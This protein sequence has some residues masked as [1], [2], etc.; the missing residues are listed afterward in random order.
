MKITADRKALSDVLA[1]VSSVVNARHT[2]PLLQ[3]VMLDV[4]DGALTLRATDL[5]VSLQYTMANAAAEKNGR[6][7][8]PATKLA[9]LVRD[10]RADT[11]SLAKKGDTV[12]VTCGRDKLEMHSSDPDHF[13]AFPAFSGK[14]AMEVDARAFGRSLARTGKSIATER[15]RY[16]LN[17]VKMTP[18]ANLIE[19]C[20]TD[21]RRLALTKMPGKG[22]EISYPVIIPRR[23]IDLMIRLLAEVGEDTPLSLEINEN[24]MLAKYG[25][26]IA[27]TALVDGQFPEYW[28]VIPTTNDKTV[29]VSRTELIE[30]VKLATHMT[31]VESST[32]AMHLSENEMVMKTRSS[33][34]GTAEAVLEVEYDGPEFKAGF[35]PR[36]LTEGLNLFRE[37]QVVMELKDRNTG[38]IIHEGDKDNFFFLVMPLEV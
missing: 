35:D 31:S 22:K 36:Y 23:G 13:P 24:E 11:V 10:L 37:D 14:G 30:A 1:T 18:K 8:L 20:G 34:T 29:K 27:S 33:G 12:L 5:E 28:T 15:G 16:A 26:V 32:V 9:A 19:F 7:L 25:D 38:V 4:S 21:G 2:N 3:N 17:G 6:A